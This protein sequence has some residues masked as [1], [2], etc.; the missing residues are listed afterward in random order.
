[1]SDTF[2]VKFL[3][4][5]PPREEQNFYEQ[6]VHTK[7][8]IGLHTRIVYSISLR[9]GV[10][11]WK[12]P[13]RIR[14]SESSVTSLI[15]LMQATLFVRWFIV[16]LTKALQK[17]WKSLGRKTWECS[18]RIGENNAGYILE[19]FL[20]SESSVIFGLEDCTDFLKLCR[21]TDSHYGFSSEVI[22]NLFLVF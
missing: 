13:L 3:L 4:S 11:T 15:A 9:Y 12:V 10:G 19:N 1:M 16:L 6:R 14:V 21:E 5:R 2:H 20:E 8:P 7:H 18:E 17:P 22:A